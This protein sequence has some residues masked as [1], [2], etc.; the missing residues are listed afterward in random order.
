[1]SGA[2]INAAGIVIGGGCGMIFKKPIPNLYQLALKIAL[3]V[4]TIWFGLRL[5]WVS[6]NGNARQV[7][8]EISIMLLAMAAGK[9]VG[10]L[11]RLQRTSNSVGHY[12]TRALAAPSVNKQFSDGFLLA[13][14]LFC[15]GPLALLASVQEGLTGFSPLFVVKAG[16]DGLAAYAFYSRFGWSVLVSALPVLAL[17]GALIRVVQA[18]AP[19]LPARAWSLADSALAVDGLLIFC[20]AMLILELKKIEVADYY[21]SLIFA[22]LLTWWL[23]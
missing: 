20:V 15:V 22:P 3:G 7:L 9:F 17:E 16:A 21:P 19:L 4:Y 6:I 18:I 11:M 1:M 23:W 8:K 14:A 2:V 10:H 5:S 13:T 12:A